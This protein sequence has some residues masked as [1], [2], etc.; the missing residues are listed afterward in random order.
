MIL[1]PIFTP[2]ALIEEALVTMK[3][4][5]IMVRLLYQSGIKLQNCRLPSPP[6]ICEVWW[7]QTETLIKKRSKKSQLKYGCGYVLSESSEREDEDV[8]LTTNLCVIWRT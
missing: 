6:A 1:F 5:P 8:M 7:N 2:L 3:V 4:E